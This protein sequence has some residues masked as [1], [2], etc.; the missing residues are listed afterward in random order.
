MPE[1]ADK[2]KFNLIKRLDEIKDKKGNA[3]ILS[4]QEII[5]P[6][7]SKSVHGVISKVRRNIDGTQSGKPKTVF[8]PDELLSL[9]SKGLEVLSK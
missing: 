9:V 2:P 3:V 7:G 6:D 4:K 8:I 5:Q 1:F